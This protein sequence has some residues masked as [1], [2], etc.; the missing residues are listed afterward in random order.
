MHSGG[1]FNNKAYETSGGLHGVGISVVNA[2]ATELEVEVIRDKQIYLQQYSRGKA[3]TKLE[4]KGETR[5]KSGTKIT[6]TPDPE[7]F[8]DRSNF[9]PEK[10]LNFS[11][12]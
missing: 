11:K 7:I 10:L 12:I 3:L 1:K 8:K 9:D 4:K 2:L 5:Q 6:F